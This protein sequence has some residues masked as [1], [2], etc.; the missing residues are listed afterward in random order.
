MSYSLSEGISEAELEKWLKNAA[1]EFGTFDDGRVDYTHAHTAPTVMCTIVYNDEILLV[2]RG[3]GLADAEGYWSTVNGFIDEIKPVAHQARQEVGEELGLD[4]GLEQIS[5]GKSYGL[6]G[7]KEKR[8]YIVFPCR[9][10]LTKKPE[11]VLDWEHTD[12]AWIRRPELETYDTLD[13]LPYAIDTAL[14]L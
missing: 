14:G 12:F 10:V 2:K 4:V 11:I 9:V 6:R 7:A 5:V 1:E 3:Q 13:D 8:R